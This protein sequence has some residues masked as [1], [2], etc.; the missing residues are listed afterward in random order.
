MTRNIKAVF[1]DLNDTLHD[2]S[3]ERFLAAV[4]R[5]CQQFGDQK[6]ILPKRLMDAYLAGNREH[7]ELAAGPRDERPLQWVDVNAE[8]WARTLADCGYAGVA[9]PSAMARVLF[10]ERVHS[11]QPFAD[12]LEL[13]KRL[14]REYPLGLVTNGQADMQRATLGALGL[15]SY[16]RVIVI[17][18]ELGAGKPSAE[19]FAEAAR[20]AGVSLHEAMHVGNSLESDVAGAKKAGMTAVWL[21]RRRQKLQPEDPQPDYLVDSLSEVA[22][23]LSA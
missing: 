15:E 23:L 16:F 12:T 17:S 1:F 14:V 21:N 9:D 5:T 13:L 6:G 8:I 10:Q 2:D 3:A 20:S 18:G 19:I 7:Y 4:E 11:F 22:A